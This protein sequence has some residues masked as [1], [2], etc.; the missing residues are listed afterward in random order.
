MNQALVL[1]DR[2]W[3]TNETVAE[4]RTSSR[5]EEDVLR[6]THRRLQLG[7]VDRRIEHRRRILPTEIWPMIPATGNQPTTVSVT[8]VKPVPVIEPLNARWMSEIRSVP[9]ANLVAIVADQN[10]NR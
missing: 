4:P 1:W 10:V 5:A 9:E 2:N 6:H 8:F 7:Q 3:S